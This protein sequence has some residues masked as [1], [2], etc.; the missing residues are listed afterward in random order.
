MSAERG[1]RRRRLGAALALLALARPGTAQEWPALVPDR[2]ATGD[3]QADA[4]PVTS[5]GLTAAVPEATPRGDSWSLRVERPG[6]YRVE[7]RSHDFDAWL[8]L[9]DGDGAVLAEDDDGLLAT[10]ARLVVDLFPGV[11]YELLACSLD[12]SSGAYSLSLAAGEAPT[13]TPLE[14][15]TALRADREARVAHARDRHGL[16]HPATADAL[17]LLGEL[18]ERQGDLDGAEQATTLALQLREELLGPDH[19]DTAVS[20]NNLAVLAYRRGDLARA[21]ELFERAVATLV[22]VHGEHSEVVAGAVNN[23]A[24]LSELLGDFAGARRQHERALAIYEATVG[25]QAPQTAVSLSNL[26][27]LLDRLG[28]RQRSKALHERALAISEASLGPD[29]PQTAV[30]LGALG[31]WAL[32]HGDFATA[33]PLLERCLAIHEATLGPDHWETANDLNNLGALHAI[34]GDPARARPLY[35]RALEIRRQVFGEDNLR[36]GRSLHN[37]ADLTNALGDSEAA[38]LLAEQ[39]LAILTRFLGGAHEETARAHNNL[40]Q[41]LVDLGQLERAEQAQRAALEAF[42]AGLGEDHP[43]TANA[44]GNLGRILEQ[45]GDDGAALELFDRACQGLAAAHGWSHPASAT[46]RLNRGRSLRR[47]GRPDEAAADMQAALDLFTGLVGAGHPRT[48]R[49]RDDLALLHLEQGRQD[50]AR[51]LLLDGAAARQ[52]WTDAL[53]PTLGEVERF[54]L[55]AQDLRHLELLLTAVDGD[56]APADQAALREEVLLHKGRVGRSLARSAARIGAADDPALAALAEELRDL[57]GR[58]AGLALAGGAAGGAARLVDL[59]TLR[60]RREVLERRLLARLGSAEDDARAPAGAAALRAALPPDTAAL[61]LLVHRRRDPAGGADQELVTAWL[62]LPGAERDLRLELGPSQDLRRAWDRSRAAWPVTPAVRRGRSPDRPRPPGRDGP[63]LDALVWGRLLPHLDGIRRLVVSPDGWLGAVPLG[64]LTLPDGTPALTR[65][66][67]VRHDDLAS[68]P[69]LLAREPGPLGA[70]LL[71]VGDVASSAD[72]PA[73]PGSAAELAALLDLHRRARGAQAPTTVLTGDEARADR[74]RQALPAHALVHLATHG[75][76]HREGL[77]SLWTSVR[78]D[79]GSLSRLAGRHPA[80]LSGLVCAP[81]PDDPD[82]PGLL[83][84]EELGW[85]DLSG[86][87]L[88]TL[89]AC[90]SALG[91]PRAAEGLL[92]LTRSLRQ[93]GAGAV[94]AS[95]WPI[96]DDDTVALMTRFYEHLLVDGLPRG[97]A[98]RRAQLDQLQ[99]LADRPDGG[100]SSW[101][102]FVLTGD[103]R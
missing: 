27:L 56:A 25:P 94:V 32:E 68:L 19:G 87:D 48:T 18:L 74:V 16:R 11:T 50:E 98:L 72:W 65:F 103:W 49:C 63:R 93:A 8:L 9:R 58:L 10:H 38:R 70:G 40:A 99:A 7:L 59:D 5:P 53:L 78:A 88:V 62:T 22:A 37:L 61:D 28:E 45:R 57:Q 35:E 96:A 39:A 60:E 83:S 51:A 69:S 33:R 101:G 14:Q 44:R 80:L 6:R 15:A 91:T 4:P 100:R 26:G 43:E 36:T 2:P 24:K 17:A 55:L 97:A 29:H 21:R 81:A 73:L 3:L 86:L 71:A 52:A 75:F 23:V 85:L 46:A 77:T 12:G 41:I 64:A 47:L 66:E 67:V 34:R 90:E 102:A 31:A 42:A 89:S 82:D 79:D 30:S 1:S 92:G 84:A 76:F 54:T 95:L 20:L 13:L